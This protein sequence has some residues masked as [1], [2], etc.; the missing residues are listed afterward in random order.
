MTHQVRLALP[1]LS[2]LTPTARIAFAVLDRRHRLLRSG[3]LPLEN[4]A[5]QLPLRSVHAILHPGDAVLLEVD[6][7]PLP[8]SRLQ[9][10]VEARIEPLVLSDLDQLCIAHGP[11]GQDGTIQVAWAS[12]QPLLEAWH[13][14]HDAGLDVR[15]LVPFE[16]ALPDNDPDP[17]QPLS[18]PAD[19]RWQAPLPKWSLARAELGPSRHAR[20][21]RGAL[22]WSMAAALVWTVGL[23]LHAAQLRNEVRALQ[24]AMEDKV[25]AAF[26]SI[27]AVLDPL[28]QAGMQVAQLRQGA[29]PST[30]SNFPALALDAARL[31]GFTAGQVTHLQYAHGRLSLR[32]AEGASPVA[33]EA[34]LKRAAGDAGLF[35]EKDADDSHV[36]HVR[37]SEPGGTGGRS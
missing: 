34:T 30:D 23:Q 32:L 15:A 19:A 5:A 12:R 2:R 25:R 35:I 8:A 20:Q 18:L 14:L 26:P 3:E 24:H 21:W 36:W 10:A 1:P 27:P 31:L 28:R 6:L 7:P 22:G 9:A 37:R 29:G 17:Q 33:N 13:R 11:R 4:L 16:L